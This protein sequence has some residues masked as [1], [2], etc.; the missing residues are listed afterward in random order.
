LCAKRVLPFEGES[1][2][3]AAVSGTASPGK[4]VPRE[5]ESEGGRPA[6]FGPGEQQPDAR[7]TRW[8]IPATDGEARN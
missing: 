3:R 6:E 5:G 1:P 8:V 4:G 7:P 2:L